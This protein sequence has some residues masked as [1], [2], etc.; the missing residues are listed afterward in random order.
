MRVALD[1]VGFLPHDQRQ[2]A[3]HLEVDQA[4]DDVDAGRFQ[5]RRPG[6]V[7]A[8][9]E[10]RLQLDQHR[11][12]LALFGRLDQQIDQ[13]R[14]RADAVQRHLDRD[15]LRIVDRRAQERLDRRERIERMVDQEVLI[16]DLLEHL[17]G[18]VG[19]PQHARM[20]DRIL[21]RRAVHLGQ[22]RPVAE[23]HALGRAHDDVFVDLEVLDQDVEHAPRHVLF[24]LQQRQRAVA[25][26]L[27]PA[28]DRFEQV[29]RLVF[30]D[31]HVGV[32]D[33]AEQ[34]RAFDVRAGKQLLDVAA[35]D[36]LEKD[37][38]DVPAAG[39]RFSGIAMK[40]GS[41]PG[42]L[43]RA[44]LV[45]PLCLTRTARF[46][47]RFEM[48]GNGWPGIEGQRRQHRERCACRSTASATDPSPACSR[49]AR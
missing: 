13:R 18:L 37:V 26:L 7:V 12:L 40:R 45:R 36:V 35:D 16:R 22:R 48:Y 14:V 31:H 4:V 41:I 43:T 25:Q 49:P 10:A 9:V 3:V 1:A 39:V 46:M 6:D 42:T 23:S 34:V 47:L 19:R 32:A 15:D 27:Q 28:V 29:V 11:H 44:N 5:P 21:Q 20:E 24:D 2:L 30:L 38:R 33:D 17:V 8:L